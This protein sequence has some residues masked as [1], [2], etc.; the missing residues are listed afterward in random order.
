MR[1]EY[2]LSRGYMSYFRSL[3]K[4]SLTSSILF[5]DQARP[6]RPYTWTD[7]LNHTHTP[8][9]HTSPKNRA[10]VTSRQWANPTRKSH[11]SFTR[12]FVGTKVPSALA[13]EG[14]VVASLLSLPVCAHTELTALQIGLDAPHIGRTTSSPHHLC[15][16]S[17]THRISHTSRVVRERNFDR[18]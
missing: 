5:F 1:D 10:L 15:D 18:K 3:F 6:I 14:P 2:K 11:P 13:S 4:Y 7:R 8:I 16:D 17:R 9:Q 12:W